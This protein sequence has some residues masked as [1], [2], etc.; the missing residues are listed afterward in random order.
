MEKLLINADDFV[1]TRELRA[2]MT[3]LLNDIKES[4]RAIVITNQGKPTAVVI[5]VEGYISLIE[6]IE[7]LQNK[8]LLAAIASARADITAGKGIALDK[9]LDGKKKNSRAKKSKRVA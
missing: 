1:G 6:T 5:S 4:N 3:S 8:E 2:N 9:Y 7:D